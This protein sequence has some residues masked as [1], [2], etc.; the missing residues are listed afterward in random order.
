MSL[1]YTFYERRALNAFVEQDFP[2]ARDL[3]IKMLKKWPQRIGI[4]HNLGLVYLG[5]RDFP[6]AE[7][8]FLKEL[9]DYGDSVSRHRAL[10][11]LYFS[12]GKASESAAH[13]NSAINLLKA[14]SKPAGSNYKIDLHFLECRL[15]I[16]LNQDA[17]AKAMAGDA[18]L[19]RGLQAQAK[20]EWDRAY[21]EFGAAVLEDPT[22]F[23]A[24]NN[25][26]SIALNI[27]KDYKEAQ[28]CFTE[29]A[30]LSSTPAIQQNLA[31]IK[32]LLDQR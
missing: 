20:K 23:P 24:W 29:A 4:R 8:C 27:Y 32:T 14:E 22:N 13:Y 17:F 2:K 26:G 15:A 25:R 28:R 21:E 1:L 9:Q 16:C 7:S 12:W 5:L 30:K 31:L 3:F 6:A 11:D 10:G 18:A 19:Q